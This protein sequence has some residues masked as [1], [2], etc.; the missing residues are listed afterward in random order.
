MFSADRRSEQTMKSTPKAVPASS[1]VRRYSTL[2][3]R[4]MVEG[5]ARALAV[6][7]ATRLVRSSSVLAI[8]MSADSTSAFRRTAE[9][10]A[11]AGQ[12]HHVEFE[13]QLLGP[14]LVDV[15]HDHVVVV[16]EAGGDR[17]PDLAGPDDDDVH[18]SS[19]RAGVSGFLS[20]APGRHPPRYRSKTASSSSRASAS[21][22]NRTVPWSRT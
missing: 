13:G 18:I 19:C 6:P 3:M 2:L 4:A 8:S 17:G 20:A 21:S 7:Q 11:V 16:V 12:R 14:V 10:G 1:L 9:W 5:S 15:H 22:A